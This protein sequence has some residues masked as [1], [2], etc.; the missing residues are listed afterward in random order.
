MPLFV[1]PL[2]FEPLFIEL[3]E[4]LVVELFGSFQVEPLFVVLEV[5]FEVEVLLLLFAVDVLSVDVE[6]L[7]LLEELELVF[8]SDEL[9]IIGMFDDE[10][11]S[12]CATV[13]PCGAVPKRPS[14]SAV[15]VDAVELQPAANIVSDAAAVMARRELR[16]FMIR[17]SKI[18]ICPFVFRGSGAVPLP[19]CTTSKVTPVLRR[20]SGRGTGAG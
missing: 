9:D 15:V 10:A 8:W 6:V 11:L 12:R 17:S 19:A 16:M 20:R 4:P 7:L 1:V 13:E 18:S 2:V 3:A 14:S 5:L